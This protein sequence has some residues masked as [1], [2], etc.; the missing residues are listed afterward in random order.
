MYSLRALHRHVNRR[1]QHV[2]LRAR[3]R[4]L[5]GAHEL[6]AHAVKLHLL[7]ELAHLAIEHRSVEDIAGQAQ[8]PG[9]LM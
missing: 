1:R 9:E 7:G 6:P 8:R 5:G 3:V 4:D 2:D